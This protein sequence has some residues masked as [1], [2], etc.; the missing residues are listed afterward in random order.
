MKPTVLE[1]LSIG[2]MEDTPSYEYGGY[3][4]YDHVLYFKPLTPT[5]LEIEELICRVHPVAL[6]EYISQG[7]PY[8]IDRLDAFD[9][10]FIQAYG[11]RAYDNTFKKQKS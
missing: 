1:L 9:D 2:K 3:H 8:F 7:I 11:Q 5:S 10:A 4:N 6:S